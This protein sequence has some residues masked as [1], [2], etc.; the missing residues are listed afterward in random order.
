MKILLIGEYSWSY[1]VGS[2]TQK[3]QIN[4]F[5]E[6]KRNDSDVSFFEI[7]PHDSLFKKL[8][9][10]ISVSEKGIINGGLFRFWFSGLTDFEIVHL[11]SLR[12]Y[13]LPFFPLV[14]FKLKLLIIVHDTLSFRSLIPKNLNHFVRLLFI[15]FSSGVFVFNKSDKELLS[16]Y[17][18]NN[19]VIFVIKQGINYESVQKYNKGHASSS[20]IL[21][22]GG[23]GKEY[24]GLQF[25]RSALKKVKCDFKLII[26]GPNYSGVAD[27]DYFGSLN[28]IDYYAILADARIV[29][30]PS[31]YESFSLTA[32]EALSFGIPVMLTEQCG[33]ADYL[34][35]G[36]GCLVEAYGNVDGL[37]KNIELLL[38]DDSL[39][40]KMSRD[41]QLAASEFEWNKIIPT[42]LNIYRQV[43]DEKQ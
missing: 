18:K 9:G 3:V 12:N 43:L 21:F 22:S 11:L 42:Y 40:Q 31:I 8:F 24:K 41:A 1:V 32:L 20:T 25:L 34:I 4:I 14:F 5:E 13:M 27:E 33:I 2:S 15:K 29:V 28:E 26:C 16:K 37:A 36:N 17:R 35:S 38:T 19:Q 6:L 10:K 30:V 23:L 39:W 7:N